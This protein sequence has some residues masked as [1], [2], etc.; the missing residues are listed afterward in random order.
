MSTAGY[1]RDGV[2]AGATRLDLN[3]PPRE[4]GAA[5]R[6]QLLGRLAECLFNRYPEID[7]LSARRVAAELYGWRADG[8]LVGNGS[9]ELLAAAVRALLPRGGTLATLH[10]SFSMY[11]VLAARQG[12]RLLGAA[13]T[14]PEFAVRAEELLALGR[15][16]DLV[17]LCS[18]N[19]PTGSELSA[20]ILAAVCELGR[21]VIWDAAYIEFSGVDPV[22]FLARWPNLVVLRSFSKAWGLAGLRVG[23]LMAAPDV[24][25][26]VEG[27]LLPFGASWL[28]LAAFEAAL[29]CRDEGGELVAELI[30]ERERLRAA[31]L[32]IQRVEVAP[33][34]ANFLLLR[35][36]GVT[37]SA[38]TTAFG[39]CGLSVRRV[40]ELDAGGWVRV[41]MG[42]AGENDAV[43]AAIAEVANG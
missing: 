10:P 40:P 27:E 8:T 17:V 22:P 42:A 16:A 9:N 7:A 37:G 18:P 35:V 33:S 23:A 11:P 3:E 21:L 34:G 30:A 6:Q 43:L 4:I 1:V 25:R 14:P 5:F 29:Q 31:S 12:A 15:E 24:A 19:N 39:A 2:A 28:V 13:L 38:L 41:T 36:G 26:R 32:A 20:Q